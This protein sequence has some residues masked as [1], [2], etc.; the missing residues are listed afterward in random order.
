MLSFLK[1]AYIA[2]QTPAARS[3]L[4]RAC[5]VTDQNYTVYSDNSTRRTNEPVC[6]LKTTS[7]NGLVHVR[8]GHNI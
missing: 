3:R 6:F 8:E 1:S 7:L 2:P 4:T 5:T